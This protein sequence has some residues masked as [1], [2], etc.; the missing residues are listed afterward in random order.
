M[1]ILSFT[2]RDYYQSVY[3]LLYLC[4]LYWFYLF[5]SNLHKHRKVVYAVCLIA[6]CVFAHA[7]LQNMYYEKQTENH[8]IQQLAKIIQENQTNYVICM[9]DR[10][11]MYAVLYLLQDSKGALFITDTEGKLT[12]FYDDTLK[13]EERVLVIARGEGNREKFDTWR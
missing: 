12:D 7:S 8:E 4:V 3:P 11:S 9:R 2:K 6:I 5:V 1:L 13:N 10:S